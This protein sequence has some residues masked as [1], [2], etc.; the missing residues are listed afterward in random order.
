MPT[1]IGRH[2]IHREKDEHKMAKNESSKS[3][4]ELYREERKERLAKAA[5]KNAKNVLAKEY[6]GKGYER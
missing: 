6:Y 4:A 2:L 3:K 1:H 5:K